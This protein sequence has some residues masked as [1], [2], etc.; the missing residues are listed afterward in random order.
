MDWILQK[1]KIQL[2]EIANYSPNATVEYLEER[3][4]IA[5]KSFNEEN[6][7]LVEI[8]RINCINC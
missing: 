2:H 3:L 1:P 5:I 8:V 7:R 4:L 6:P